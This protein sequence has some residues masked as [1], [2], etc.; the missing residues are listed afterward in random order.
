MRSVPAAVLAIGVLGFVPSAIGAGPKPKPPALGAPRILY[1]SD[2]SGADEIYAVDPSGKSRVGQLTF[3]SSDLFKPMPSP[4]GSRLLFSGCGG[5]GQS[6]FVARAD[7]SGRRRLVQSN[8][9]CGLSIGAVWSADS[10]YVAYVVD[11]L[12]WVVRP[13]G[14]RRRVVGRGSD[15][16]WSST[17]SLAYLTGVSNQP[18][19]NQLVVVDPS[20]SRRVIGPAYDFAW[21]KDGSRIAYRFRA[22]GAQSISIVRSDGSR[23]R[24]V[25]T[26]EYVGVPFWSADG[27]FIG[28]WSSDGV[29]TVDLSTGKIQLLHGYADLVGWSPAGHTLAVRGDTGGL[30]V[31]DPQTSTIRLL[32]SDPV[33]YYGGRWAPDGRSSMYM[34]VYDLKSVSLAGVVRT[35]VSGAGDFGGHISGVVW[36][37]PPSGTRYRPAVQRSSVATVTSDQL[38]APWT[39]TALAADGE[40]V[41][42][43]S[44]G[45]VFAWT[46][47]TRA[48]RQ[49]EEAATVAPA[50]SLGDN[51]DAYQIYSVAISGGRVAYAQVQGNMSQSFVLV[52]SQADST[53]ELTRGM[54]YAGDSLICSG[55]CSG[56]LVGEGGLLAYSRWTAAYVAGKTVITTQEIDRVDGIACPCPTL[57]TDPGPLV[58]VDVDG[59]RIVAG[60]DN[61]TVIL[62][63][64]G[65]QLL[66]EPVVPLAATLSGNDLVI[67]RQGELLDF[68]ATTGSQT[69]R[70]PLPDVTSGRECGSK[71]CRPIFADRPWPGPR[72][73]L[74]DAAR[75][76]VAYVLDGQVHLLRLADGTDRVV[77]TGRL[78]RF[79]DTGLVYADG[80]GIHLVPF[81]RLQIR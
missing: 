44:C 60:G 72:L 80:S 21:S 11:G 39:I 7:G 12:V 32:T 63:A 8:A 79:M 13:D 30:S 41:A 43:V 9:V 35:I 62:D 59:G 29:G 75:G 28:Y 71:Y 15:P 19:T 67:L 45:H 5:T 48:V 2:W 61:S 54:G 69:H 33:Q 49:V 47:A 40:R 77:G 52:A 76:L 24:R 16:A 14:S 65:K 25:A 56:E 66:S 23:N 50:C 70:W 27:R 4:D 53:S 36:T 68:D 38:V 18:L 3:G 22:G 34:S 58:P 17:G 31:V 74:E 51:Y 46:P 57:R 1:A 26:S 78:A 55:A 6:L 42:Y 20:G 37:R 64:K 10:A 81:D 73:V